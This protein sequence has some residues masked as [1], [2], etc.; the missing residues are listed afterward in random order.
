MACA[1]LPNLHA[2]NATE[3]AHAMGT[4]ADLTRDTVLASDAK[5]PRVAVNA[6][7]QALAGDTRMAGAI[8]IRAA[9]IE[10]AHNAY[11]Q[12]N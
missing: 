3:P 9:W 5:V 12:R 10:V 6:D 8:C 4:E 2:E 1:T 7:I 11:D